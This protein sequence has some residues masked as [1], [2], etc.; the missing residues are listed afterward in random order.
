MADWQVECPMR[1]CLLAG[2]IY[3]ATRMGMWGFNGRW[4]LAFSTSVYQ[5]ELQNLLELSGCMDYLKSMEGG[6][7]TPVLLGDEIG[8]IWIAEHYYRDGKPACLI[9]FGPMFLSQLSVKS[10][11]ESLKKMTFS[12]SARV[13]LFRI[14]ESLPVMP[15]SL[16]IG[17]AHV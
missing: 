12:M 17:R 15:F 8:M 11:E 6:C 5:K 7:R 9:I 1:I 3:A 4:E 16:E 13:Q 10:V 2:H 14:L